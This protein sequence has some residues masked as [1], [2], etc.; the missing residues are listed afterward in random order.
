[1]IKRLIPPEERILHVKNFLDFICD[2]FRSSP[3]YIPINTVSPSE[4]S[5]GMTL[6]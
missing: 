3:V 1:M 5:D 4:F 6:A 2:D